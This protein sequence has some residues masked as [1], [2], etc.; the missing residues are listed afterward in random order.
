MTERAPIFKPQLTL[1]P[2]ATHRLTATVRQP[3]P[4]IDADGCRKA[5]GGAIG[6]RVNC[7]LKIGALSGIRILLSYFWAP[8]LCPWGKNFWNFF[9]RRQDTF[10]KGLRA[11]IQNWPPKNNFFWTKNIFFWAMVVRRGEK[12]WGRSIRGFPG[13]NFGENFGGNFFWQKFYR[14]VTVLT[15]TRPYP[16]PFAPCSV[17]TTPRM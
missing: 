17:L 9:S 11:A 4:L 2:I 6:F 3:L 15:V 10:F 13:K 5:V 1:K 12:L 7:G 8:R 16:F 14:R